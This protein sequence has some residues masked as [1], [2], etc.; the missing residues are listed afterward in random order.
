MEVNYQERWQA[1][2]DF[3][4]DIDERLEAHLKEHPPQKLLLA[5]NIRVLVLPTQNGEWVVLLNGVEKK[6]FY[7][8]HA[9]AEASAYASKL[10]NGET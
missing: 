10:I 4:K 8:P 7:G 3:K 6:A 2:A 5:S 9:H 1:F